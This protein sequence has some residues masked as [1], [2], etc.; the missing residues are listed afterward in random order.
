[1]KPLVLDQ[2]VSDKIEKKEKPLILDMPISSTK[3]KNYI[4]SK[5]KKIATLSPAVRKI[6][7]EQKIDITQVEGTGKNGQIVKGDVLNLMRNIPGPSKRK[8]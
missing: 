7:K 2:M 6:V 4:F 5:I 8:N 3:K 1:M